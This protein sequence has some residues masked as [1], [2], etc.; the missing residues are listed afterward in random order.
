VDIQSQQAQ[1]TPKKK[2]PKRPNTRTHNNQFL[3]TKNPESST[4][5]A[6]FMHK[7]NSSRLVRRNIIGKKGVDKIFK[8]IK[9]KLPNKNTV[10]YKILLQ[11]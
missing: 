2:Y 3:M 10:F 11:K 7:R 4:R 8:V 1:R 6:T 9:E 5:K